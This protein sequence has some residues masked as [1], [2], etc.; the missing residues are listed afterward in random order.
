M[1]VNSYPLVFTSSSN[2]RASIYDA[3]LAFFGAYDAGSNPNGLNAVY[4]AGDHLLFSCAPLGTAY[5]HIFT[6]Y[7]RL[8][9]YYGTG[10]TSGTALDG[11]VTLSSYSQGTPTTGW[12]AID[13]NLLFVA[14]GQVADY[15]SMR[16]AIIGLDSEG[17]SVAVTWFGSTTSNYHINYTGRNIT[18]DFA[19]AP[20]CGWHS[21]FQGSNGFI[22]EQPMY[23]MDATRALV[24]NGA[25]A[26]VTIP[27]VVNYSYVTSTA[28]NVGDLYMTFPTCCHALGNDVSNTCFG[29]K[30]AVVN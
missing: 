27:G 4:N 5:Y 11:E 22:V 19:V 26:L 29:I 9:V 23:L 2:K 24:V 16:V 18:Q 25:N 6:E 12:I 20:G 14:E 21:A 1:T 17:D 13:D 8:F 3:L 15:R 10:Y 30:V 7:N 28:T